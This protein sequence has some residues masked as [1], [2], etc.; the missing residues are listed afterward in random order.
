MVL[1]PQVSQW[2][3]ALCNLVPA[4]LGK[5]NSRT[6]MEYMDPCQY[7]GCFDSF[8][9]PIRKTVKRSSN[10]YNGISYNGNTAFILLFYDKKSE[11]QHL[12]IDEML[13]SIFSK[14]LLAW[15]AQ[16]SNLKTHTFPYKTAVEF[17]FNGSQIQLLFT[18]SNTGKGNDFMNMA[19]MHEEKNTLF[20]Y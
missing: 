14:Y 3:L 17:Q 18:I 1:G 10:L 9:N 13:L 15:G 16:I 19:Y 8:R 7:K 12:R 5:W 6:S 2:S 20:H 11:W 4:H